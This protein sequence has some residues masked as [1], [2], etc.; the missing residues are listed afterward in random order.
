MP[1][2]DAEPPPRASRS[3]AVTEGRKAFMRIEKAARQAFGDWVL[4]AKALAQGRSE[5]LASTGANSVRS[6]AYRK[7]FEQWL[8]AEPWA[9]R[10]PTVTRSAC[11]WLADRLE[12]V[13]AW[14]SALPEDKRLALNHPGAIK[15]RFDAERR[16]PKPPKPS[17]Q[18]DAVEL[19][20]LRAK[21]TS[22]GLFAPSDTDEEIAAALARRYPHD[23]VR[24]IAE[25]LLAMLGA[26]EREA[27]H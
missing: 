24:R 18:A 21:V 6:T 9:R 13:E 11:L 16:P 1:E 26:F 22:E 4:V 7:A 12:E 10:I 5:A 17:A 23:R 2:S 15:R 14:R 3:K 27:V 20:A 25:A 19:D 8:T